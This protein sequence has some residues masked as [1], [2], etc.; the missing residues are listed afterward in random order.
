MNETMKTIYS[1]RSVH[2][3]FSAKKIPDGDMA[4]II[5]AALRAANASARQSYSMVALDDRG[6]MRRISGY[7]G[8]RLIVFC[9]DFSRLDDVGKRLGHDKPFVDFTSFVTGAI[10]AILAAQT[11]CVAARSLGVDSLFTN[12]IHRAPLDSVY[13]ELAL[14]ERL[15]FPLIALVLGYPESEPDFAK[16]R[17]SGRG[18]VHYGKYSPLSEGEIDSLVG[19]YDD[20]GR[21]LGLYGNWKA[22]GYAHYLDWFY[23]RWQGLAPADKNAEMKERLEKSGFM[24]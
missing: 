17:V 7:E 4:A 23:E 21:H 6:A 5:D 1:L 22:D 2:G 15:C 19:E 13:A 14:P 9:V 10:D 12:G 18:I 11:A 16:G 3:D 20:P 8:D 24:A